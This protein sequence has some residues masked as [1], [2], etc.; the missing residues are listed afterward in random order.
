MVKVCAV[1]TPSNHSKYIAAWQTCSFLRFSGKNSAELPLLHENY[2]L[3]FPTLS[4]ARYS[5]I[6]LSELRHRG[7]NS[8]ADAS[9]WYQRGTPRLRGHHSTATMLSMHALAGYVEG[10]RL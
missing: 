6:Q 2:S 1:S 8:N 10:A 3:T 4:I 5:F 7:V 9:K